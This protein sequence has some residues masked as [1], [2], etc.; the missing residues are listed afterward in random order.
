MKLRKDLVLR[1][2]GDEYVIVDPSQNVIDMSRVFTLNETAAYIWN[3]LDGVV[4]D[5]EFIANILVNHYEVELIQA[6]KDANVLINKFVKEG[7]LED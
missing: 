7:L 4:F 1:K 3:K 5:N 2:M 6:L